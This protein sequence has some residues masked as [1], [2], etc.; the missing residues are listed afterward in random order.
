MNVSCEDDIL[1]IF[2]D[3]KVRGKSV[4]VIGTGSHS[5]K[6]A[7]VIISTRE[8]SHFEVKDETV[9]AQAGASL[10][11]IREETSSM[12][13]LLPTFYD[14]TMGGLLALN[15]AYPIS[16]TYGTPYSFT[17]W[18]RVVTPVGVFRWKGLIG[19][20]GKLGA[21]TEASIKL[22]PR[23]SKV[24]TFTKAV[25]GQ[26]LL[27]LYEKIVDAKPI[28]FLIEY[29]GKYRIHVSLTEGNLLGM[30]YYEGVP[31]VEGSD[32]G[33]FMVETKDLSSFIKLVEAT[34]PIYAYHILGVKWSKVY[35]GEEA[36]L[37]GWN[38][39]PSNDVPPVVK[40]LKRVID[41][42]NVLV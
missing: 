37:E 6:S 17:D 5:N 27:N 22:F 24:I 20:K 36:E 21:F 35:I 4:A 1:E 3:A 42:L 23:P 19:S 10:T 15:E 32:K 30:E 9:V 8:M 2:K 13:L 16:T 7:D 25:N 33:S 38:Y 28:A 26:E 29:D 39:Y 18:V 11:K 31:L 34:S 41:H 40:K 12:G 14:G